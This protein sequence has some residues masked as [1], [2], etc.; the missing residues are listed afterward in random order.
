MGRRYERPGAPSAARERTEE[1][2][3][4]DAWRALDRGV[5]PTVDPAAD[6]AAD[7]TDAPGSGTH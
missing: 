3:T 6:P 5:D 4:T 2:R 7:P 1:E